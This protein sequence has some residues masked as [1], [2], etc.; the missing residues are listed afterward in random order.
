MKLEK[1][2]EKRDRIN[3][4]IELEIAELPNYG[5]ECHCGGDYETVDLIHRGNHFDETFTYCTNCGGAVV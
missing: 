4:E 5:G 3:E 1:L 2:I